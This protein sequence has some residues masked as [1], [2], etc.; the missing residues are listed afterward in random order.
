MNKS[1]AELV[2][3]AIVLAC[4]AAVAVVCYSSDFSWIDDGDGG[5][6]IGILYTTLHMLFYKVMFILGLTL[7]S[8]GG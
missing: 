2:E 8:V 3:Y 5:Y 6:Q 1:G 7:D 4:I